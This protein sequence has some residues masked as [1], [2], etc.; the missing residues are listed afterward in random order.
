M[1]RKITQKSLSINMGITEN[2][3]WM[4]E[5]GLRLPSLRLFLRITKYFD[6]G[7]SYS[8][9]VWLED[10]VSRFSQETQSAIGI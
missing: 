9:R 2:H 10:S 1:G 7:S 8:K 4:V 5:N 6:I 3:L